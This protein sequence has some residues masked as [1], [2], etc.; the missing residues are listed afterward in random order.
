MNKEAKQ[1]LNYITN[2]QQE[3]QEANDSITWWRNR[4]N[5]VQQ[6]NE[7]LRENNQNMQE[8]KDNLYLDNAM[9]KMEKDIYKTGYEELKDLLNILQ[10]GSGDIK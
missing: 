8:E 4:F 6:E 10:N 1:L 2:L 7:T 9:L 3:I 5:A